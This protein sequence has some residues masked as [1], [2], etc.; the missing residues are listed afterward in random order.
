M[1]KDTEE[2]P[3]WLR[4]DLLKFPKPNFVTKMTNSNFVRNL[5]QNVEENPIPTILAVGAVLAG[6]AKI[7]DAVGRT[8]GSHA[9]AKQVNYRINKNK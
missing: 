3:Q 5:K 9:Y 8:K 6:V 2:I 1:D 7:I 4:D